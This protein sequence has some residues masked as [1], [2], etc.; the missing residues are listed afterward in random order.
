LVGRPN[1]F[2]VTIVLLLFHPILQSFW[3]EQVL[4]RMRIEARIC[5]YVCCLGWGTTGNDEA[6]AAFGDSENLYVVGNTDA[7]TVDGW[8]NSGSGSRN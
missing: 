4:L 6:K 5:F 8:A 3:N 2:H 1:R 7:R